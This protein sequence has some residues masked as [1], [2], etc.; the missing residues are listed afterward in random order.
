M[1]GWCLLPD[2]ESVP[3]LIRLLAKTAIIVLPAFVYGTYMCRLEDAE[4]EAAAREDDCYAPEATANPHWRPQSAHTCPDCV[5]SARVEG[6]FTAPRRD[7]S[8]LRA[9]LA[10]GLGGTREAPA[11]A[12]HRAPLTGV[13]RGAR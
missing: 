9:A 5:E 10:G 11:H 1:S 12:L 2:S 6:Q 4:I 3:K 7:A 13:S 8:L